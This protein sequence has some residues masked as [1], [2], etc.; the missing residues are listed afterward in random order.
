VA[1][2][3]GNDHRSDR[4]GRFWK[5]H[6]AGALWV[7]L[8]EGCSPNLQACRSLSMSVGSM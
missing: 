8:P 4:L 2:R 1:S 7:L 5:R 6:R 3:L